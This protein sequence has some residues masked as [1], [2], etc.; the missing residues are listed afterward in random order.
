MNVLVLNCGSSSIKYQV[1]N[2]QN[3]SLLAKGLVERIGGEETIFNYQKIGSEKTK[4]VAQNINYEKA[5]S[6]ILNTICDKQIGVLTDIHDLNAIGHRVVHGGEYF[7]DSQL[8]TDEVEKRIEECIDLAPLHN[9]ANLEGIKILR[10]MLPDVPN[11]AVFDTAFHQTM[12]KNSF[13]Y[14]LPYNLYNKYKIRRYG[15][16]G[17]SHKYVAEQAALKLGKPL[18]ECNLI[19]CHLGNGCSITAIKNGISV[20]TS[21]GFTPL[22]GLMMGTRCGDIDP[23]IVL[24]LMEKENLSIEQVNSLMNKQSGLLGISGISNDIRLIWE[25]V[26]KGNEQAQLA[27]DMFIYRLRKYIGSYIAVLG[28]VDAIVFTAGIGENDEHVREKA[29]IG[30]EEIGIS[31]DLEK[32]IELNRKEGEIS[33]PESKIKV[34]I[35][36]TNEE[37]AIAK[38]TKKIVDSIK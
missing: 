14:A 4:S 22:E 24:Y 2:M 38:D 6:I 9:P 10:K 27:T 12:P 20:D 26:K 36:P 23:Y 8:I 29:L 5:I 32:N 37:L 30:L 15:F 18:N 13:I 1:I 16:H 3:E 28:R 34:F 35:I 7:F 21:M 31:I 19:T 17:T 25:E 33:K 11:I